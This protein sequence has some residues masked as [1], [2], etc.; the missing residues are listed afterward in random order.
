M[1]TRRFPTDVGDDDPLYRAVLEAERD[2]PLAQGLAE[3]DITI[4]DG[5]APPGT[6]NCSAVS[7][8]TVWWAPA[9][10]LTT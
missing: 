9:A 5:L 4:E 10:I 6:V 8:I 3:C 1:A 2:E 7:F